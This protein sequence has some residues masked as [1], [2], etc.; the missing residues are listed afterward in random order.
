MTTLLRRGAVPRAAALSVVLFL[1]S[2]A[3][4]GSLAAVGGCAGADSP[5]PQSAKTLGLPNWVGTDKELFDDQIDPSALGLMPSQL[6]RRD[7]TLWARAQQ[8]EI[9]G[10]VR[11]Q[12][13]TVDSRGGDSTYHLGLR[14]ANELLGPTDLEDR[15]F[16]VTIEPRDP[17]YGIAKALDTGLHGRTF[18]GFLKRFAGADDQ[19]EVHFFLA[20]DSAE[21]AKAVQEAVAI[22]E[23]RKR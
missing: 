21:I 20:P 7:E 11:V 14:F 15:D 5:E 12:T 2:L 10:R 13:V 17:A 4:A 9:I 8:A 1:G 19:V 3:A 18:V 16:E 23:V 6:G 22:K